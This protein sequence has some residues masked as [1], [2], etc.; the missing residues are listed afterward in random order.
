M[1]MMGS[2]MCSKSNGRKI[3]LTTPQRMGCEIVRHVSE[4]PLGGDVNFACTKHN[5]WGSDRMP[6]G[7][8]CRRTCRVR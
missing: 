3:T 8:R 6:C 4:W 2:D 7:M 1:I 5:V